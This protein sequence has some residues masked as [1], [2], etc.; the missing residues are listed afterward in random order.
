M[1]I[2]LI[3][4]NSTLK[5]NDFMTTKTI[6]QVKQE[7]RTNGTTVSDWAKKH[8]YSP[9]EVYKVINQQHKGNYGR[10]HEIAVKLGL[11]VTNKVTS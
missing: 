11:K 8:G 2:D 5:G 10:S 1:K 7:F 6:E 4:T 3:R 9:Q